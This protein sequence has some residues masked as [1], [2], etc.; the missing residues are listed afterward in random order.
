M[1][2]ARSL[3]KLKESD[4]APKL[5]SKTKKTFFPKGG[6]LKNKSL[7]SLRL[8]EVELVEKASAM[9]GISPSRM[10]T[11][12]LI[13]I[14]CKE[15]EAS[16]NS[17]LSKKR[18]FSVS[19]RG[20]IGS[21]DGRLRDGYKRLINLDKPITASRLAQAAAT[22]FGTAKRWVERFHPELINNNSNTK[23]KLKL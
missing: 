3:S 9:S 18:P 12:G 7:Q 1:F 19:A 13:Q 4:F 11:L 20:K 8:T 5:D 10:A 2:M 22:S 6:R 17:K 14:A 23:T 15:I 16:L 21:A